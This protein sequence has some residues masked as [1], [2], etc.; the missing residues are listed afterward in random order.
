[1]QCHFGNNI[2][3]EYKLY[4]YIVA[5]K[6]LTSLRLTKLKLLRDNAIQIS[7]SINRLI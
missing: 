4:C 2:I 1:M 5:C 7:T 6:L 3:Y